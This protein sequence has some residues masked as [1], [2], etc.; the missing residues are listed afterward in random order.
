MPGVVEAKVVPT[1]K[2]GRAGFDFLGELGTNLGDLKGLDTLVY[3]LVQNADDAP[4]ATAMRFDVNDDAL[5]VWNDGVFTACGFEDDWDCSL[6]EGAGGMRIPCDFHSFKRISAQAKREQANTIGAF[7]IGFTSVFQIADH[8]ELLSGGKHWILHYERP[9]DRRIDYCDGCE[10]S[11]DQEGTIFVLPWACDGSS[12]VRKELR[13]PPTVADIGDQFIIEAL[14]AVPAAMVFLRKLRTIELRQGGETTATFWRRDD[15]N[16]RRTIFDHATSRAYFALA[17]DFQ[18]EAKGLRDDYPILREDRREAVCEIAIPLDDKQELL[19]LYAVLPTRQKSSLQ[20][21]L[22]AS[23]YPYKNR[24]AIKFESGHDG[25]SAWNRAALRAVAPILA[26][27]LDELPA[28]LGAE[29]LWQVIDSIRRVATDPKLTIDDSFA[30][31]W[32]ELVPAMCDAEIVLAANEEWVTPTDAVLVPEGHD[33]VI[34]VLE[35]L[36]LSVASPQIRTLVRGAAGDLGI[37]RLSLDI[38]RNPL[39]KAGLSTTK[40]YVELEGALADEE[41]RA[42]L[43]GLLAQLLDKPSGDGRIDVLDG[44]A[45]IPCKGS[46]FVCPE[47]AYCDSG[48]TADLLAQIPGL[49]FVDDALVE[50]VASRLL[51]TLEPIGA[52]EVIARLDVLDG[53]GELDDVI[54]QLGPADLLRWLAGRADELDDDDRSILRALP[55]FPTVDGTRPLGGLSL[56]GRFDRD[57][58]GR[59]KT[60]ALEEIADLCDF[61]GALGAPVLSFAVYVRDVLAPA[62]SEPDFDPSTEVLDELLGIVVEHYALIDGDEEL[63]SVLSDLPLVPCRDGVRRAAVACYFSDNLIDDL[64]VDPAIAVTPFRGGTMVDHLYELLGVARNPRSDDLVKSVVSTVASAKTKTAQNRVRKILEYLGPQFAFS[65]EDERAAKE[66]ELTELY[67]ELLEIEWLPVL[68]EEKW[69][70]PSELFRTEFRGAIESVGRFV[71]LPRTVQEHNADFLQLLGVQYHPPVELVI[72]HLMENVRSC[73]RV[74]SLVYELLDGNAGEP[75]V[76]ALCP[77]ECLLVATEPTVVY[78]CPGDVVS[79]SHRLGTHVHTIP[80]A[81]ARFEQL[82]ETLGVA[83]EPGIEHA[84]NVLKRLAES[85]GPGDPP[86]RTD[87]ADERVLHECW[88]IIVRSLDDASDQEERSELGARIERELSELPCWPNRRGHLSPPGGLL[89]GDRPELEADMPGEML[90]RIIEHPGDLW[91]ALDYAG[92]RVVSAVLER[93]LLSAPGSV[94]NEHITARLRERAAQIE[95]I[96]AYE[97]SDVGG[98]RSSLD[99]LSCFSAKKVVVQTS[100]DI[101]GECCDL[102]ES[103]QSAFFDAESHYLYVVAGSV[104]VDW[105]GVALELAPLL[106]PESRAGAIAGLIEKALAASTLE[107][108]EQTLSRN[109]VPKLSDA[110][111]GLEPPSADE[112]HVFVDDLDREEDAFEPDQVDDGATGVDVEDIEDI[113]E[114]EDLSSESSSRDTYED[115]PDS[116]ANNGLPAADDEVERIETGERDIDAAARG[117]GVAPPAGAG[118]GAAGEHIGTSGR[119]SSGRPLSEPHRMRDPVRTAVT[120]WR[121]WV[122]GGAGSQQDERD[123]DP[124]VVERRQEIERCGVGRVKQ[125]EL[126]HGRPVVEIMPPN[127]PGFDVKSFK[128]AGRPVERKIEVKSLAGEWRAEAGGAGRSLPQLTAEQYRQSSDSRH[129]LYVVEY[130]PDDEAWVV[131]PIQSVGQR[132]N[133]FLFDDGWKKAADRPAGPGVTENAD[134]DVAREP[135]L[136]DVSTVV[137][138]RTERAEGDVPYLEARQLELVGSPDIATEADRWFTPTTED[139]SEGDFA[140]QQLDGAMGRWLPMGAVAVFRP[141]NGSFQNNSVVLA[142]VAPEASDSPVYAVRRA[143]LINGV[144]GALEGLL[145]DV[146]VPGRG[147]LFEFHDPSAVGRVLAVL[148]SYQE[149]TWQG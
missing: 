49:W 147:E 110:V 9:E 142:N 7:G 1:M 55:I 68:G 78:A 72:R 83:V 73:T 101:D 121:T 16:G 109:H 145:L 81:L 76:E 111:A 28:A 89:V 39:A 91:P 63:R 60:V 132:A 70:A 17:G 14:D 52:R 105:E 10:R 99:R 34:P 26:A 47:E 143:F 4:G 148:V 133:R 123:S 107:E 113:D 23:F 66:A 18:A 65:G 95:R 131:Y 97:R 126:E 64:L 75:A 77:I 6:V 32:R 82:L 48:S 59:A 120:P 116:V 37:R 86:I 96:V 36:G 22:S 117:P 128:A 127:H 24:K 57:P 88:R 129:W 29:R 38:L 69:S 90:N 2:T 30:D 98:A 41:G 80:G 104:G 146:D 25:E 45:V 112:T 144:D 130:A 93:R 12:A 8:P 62:F 119:G 5:V 33:A 35:E 87:H 3:E 103:S 84:L 43:I 58:I 79:R 20:F 100:L 11:H 54:K 94:E 125:Y 139:V 149:P 106:C 31:V 56:P 19:P 122:S 140:V 118:I 136:P 50:R 114:A 141:A 27:S 134:D 138:G 71:D 21:L 13:A 102:P 61:L 85:Y 42:A 92:L 51:E 15:S 46:A 40:P 137:F 44:C 115:V 74:H 135:V 53:L 124:S 108:A 67:A